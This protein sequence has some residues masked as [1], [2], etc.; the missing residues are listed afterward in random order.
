MEE[1][2][3]TDPR[4]NMNKME[5]CVFYH[6]SNLLNCPTSFVTNSQEFY[7]V[8]FYKCI[9]IRIW[10]ILLYFGIYQIE[11]SLCITKDYTTSHFM[12]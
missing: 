2:N 9:F 3:S 7:K 12:L 10:F 4:L 6:V 11:T 1:V 8:R 5:Q